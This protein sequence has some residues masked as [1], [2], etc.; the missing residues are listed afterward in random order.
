M[1]NLRTVF[2][3]RQVTNREQSHWKPSRRGR[4][5]LSRTPAFLTPA[6]AISV[7]SQLTF[8]RARYLEH[9]HKVAENVRPFELPGKCKRTPE[10]VILLDEALKTHEC[11]EALVRW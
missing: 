10:S 9:R 4:L 2:R 5:V 1:K 8:T 11:L 7:P 3:A 6:V